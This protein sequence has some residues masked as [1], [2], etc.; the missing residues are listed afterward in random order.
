MLR[1][2][3]RPHPPQS[4]IAPEARPIVLLHGFASTPRVMG[5]LARHLGRA[6]G[7]ETVC[8]EVS[9]TRDLRAQAHA[10]LRTVKELAIRS[11]GPVDAVAHSMGGLIATYAMKALDRGRHIATVVTLGTPHGGAPL[12]RMGALLKNEF[13]IVLGQMQPGA[14]FLAELEGLPVPERSRLV[15]VAGRRD[16]VV[17][18]DSSR[19]AAGER[20]RTLWVDGAT[21]STLLISRSV[22][23][24]VAAVLDRPAAEPA[25]ALAAA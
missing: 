21:H 24:L 25:R 5:P 7:S 6:R 4:R 9:S 19:V 10:V 12:A 15:S 13:A 16:L 20:Q 22:M 11:G 18:S 3:D 8:A 2:H 1:T 14:G 23:R 17:P